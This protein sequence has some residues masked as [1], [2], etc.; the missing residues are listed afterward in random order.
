MSG[1]LVSLDAVFRTIVIV[2]DQRLEARRNDT[3]CLTGYWIVTNN[4]SLD[5]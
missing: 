1:R 4:G 2:G 5:H 3:V